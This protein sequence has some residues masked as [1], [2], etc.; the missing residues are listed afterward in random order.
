MLF[1]GLMG[2]VA[3]IVGGVIWEVNPDAIWWICLLGDACL[4]LPLM[5]IIGCKV[6]KTAL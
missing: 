5:M 2:V 1:N 4:S 3:P 6:S